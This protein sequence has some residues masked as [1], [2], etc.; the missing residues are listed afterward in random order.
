MK[1]SPT[2]LLLLPAVLHAQEAQA[3]EAAKAAPV[4]KPVMEEPGAEPDPFGSGTF[5]RKLPGVPADRATKLRIPLR[6]RLET[7][8]APA[9][10]VA[11]RLDELRGA[12]SLAA[13]RAECLAGQ[14]GVTLVHSPVT[15]IDSSTNMELE[16]ISERIY[17]TQY[18]PPQIPNS[19]PLPKGQEAGPKVWPD[20]LEKIMTSATPTS[21]E[22]RNT[23][24]TL[25]A[26]AQP[27]AV[28]EKSWD[29]V[30]GFDCVDFAGD[31]TYG[32]NSLHIAM[33]VMGSFRTG[34][35]L[36]LKEGQW[37]LLSVTE[38]PRG[39]DGKPSDQRWVT[40][41]RIDPEE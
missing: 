9:M 31:T 29:V 3:P 6:L 15:T 26:V 7:W 36:R 40:L 23:G 41:L 32:E 28:V 16:S 25:T 22:T 33:P 11:K 38:P 12:E 5:E 35:L 8:S 34:G 21:F 24:S 39:L 30:V 13:L 14:P 10:E 2:L 4:D 18:E 27:V 37:R 1:I 19:P 20:W 17:P